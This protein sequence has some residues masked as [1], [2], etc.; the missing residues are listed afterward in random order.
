[1][2]VSLSVKGSHDLSLIGRQLC[3]YGISFTALYIPVAGFHAAEIL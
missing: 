1:M 3:P 2:T